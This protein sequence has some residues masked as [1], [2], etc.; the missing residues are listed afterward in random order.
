MH[1]LRL[2][3]LQMI[4]N[5][6]NPTQITLW[7][8]GKFF[9]DIEVPCRKVKLQKEKEAGRLKEDPELKA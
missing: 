3:Y 1:Q 8:A 2:L 4:K 6:Q 9:M 5:D 7:I